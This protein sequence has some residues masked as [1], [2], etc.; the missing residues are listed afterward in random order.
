MAPAPSGAVVDHH[1]SIHRVLLTK[2]LTKQYRQQP[3]RQVSPLLYPISSN[4][5]CKRI[6]YPS[7][8]VL[9]TAGRVHQAGPGA[10]PR[11]PHR[12]GRPIGRL[13]SHEG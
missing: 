9:H 1:G 12:I 3:R 4:A 10:H 2:V 13:L 8:R 11:G 5:P 6:G 7:S